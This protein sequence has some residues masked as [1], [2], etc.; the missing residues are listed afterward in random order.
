MTEKQPPTRTQ[1][2][3]SEAIEHRDA[4][5]DVRAILSTATG[6]RFFKYLLK[7]YS[8]IELPPMG[9]EGAILH[10]GLGQLRAFNE[11]FNLISEAA[12]EIAAAIL[13]ETVKEKNEK[14]S[15]QNIIEQGR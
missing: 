12:P 13:A 8:P 6:R 11:L 7:N 4:L 14:L 5:L 9:L 10:E 2:E 15:K 1:E 3:V